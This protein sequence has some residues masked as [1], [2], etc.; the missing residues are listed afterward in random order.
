MFGPK[1]G[2]KVPN[3]IITISILPEINQGL[4]KD[5]FINSLEKQIYSEL[6]RLN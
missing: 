1:N 4:T 6:D 5:N 3:K 2:A